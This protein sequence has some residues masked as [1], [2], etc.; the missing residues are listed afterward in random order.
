MKPTHRIAARMGSRASRPALLR[1]AAA[2]LVA[3]LLSVPAASAFD[4]KGHVVIEALAYRTLIEGHDGQPPRPEVLRDLFDDGD[5]APPL[6]FGW[7]DHPPGFCADATTTN[8][9]LAW[10]KP[11]TDQPDAAFR[12]QFSDAGQCFHFMATLEDAESPEIEG[13]AIPRGLATSALVRCRDLLDNLMR[14]VVLDGGPGARKGGYGLYELMHSVEDSF[15]GSHT[16]RR[17]VTFQ[18]EE[19]RIWK[20]LTRMPD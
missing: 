5:L 14:Q 3:A 17:P 10:P 2:A 1:A 19:L 12:R 6:C 20:P 18:I 7:G 8:P 13:T 11:L 9:L 4:S 16:Q 15:S